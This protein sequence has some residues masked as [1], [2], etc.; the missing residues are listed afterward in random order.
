VLLHGNGE[1][2]E[3]FSGQIEA[4]ARHFRVIAVDTRG[5]GNSPRGTGPFTLRRFAEDLRALFDKLGIHKADIL[6]F[7]DGGNTALLFALGWP[8]RVGKLILVGANFNPFGLKPGSL[9]EVTLGWLWE[10][11]RSPFSKKARQRREMMALMLFQP[12]LR[13]VQLRR[14]LAETLV[15]A[16]SRDVIS[17]RH[18]QRLAQALPRAQIQILEGSHFVLQENPQAFN[19]AVLA[20]LRGAEGENERYNKLYNRENGADKCK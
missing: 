10:A 14:I 11:V 5:H 6:G 13:R 19:G 3:I 4:F 8:E 9:L 2:H 20:F 1:S 7:S 12:R 17:P 18:T 16:G 15:I